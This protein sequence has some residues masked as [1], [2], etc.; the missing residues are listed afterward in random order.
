MTTSENDFAPTVTMHAPI[1][2]F[3]TVFIDA[4]GIG[5]I[6]PVLPDLIEQLTNLTTSEAAIWG[7]YLSVVYASMQFIFSPTIGNLSD[8][9]GRRP[10]LLLSLAMLGINYLL[11]GLAGSIIILFIGRFLSGVAAATMATANAYMA[12]IS[13]PEKRIQ[14]FG[15]LGAAFGMGFIVGP[16][17][18]GLIGELGVR[19]PFYAAAILSLLNCLYGFFVIPETLNEDRRRPFEWKRA[20]PLGSFKQMAQMPKVFWFLITMFFFSL[21][22]FVYPAVWNFFAKEA[23]DWGSSEIGLSLAAVGVCFAIVQGLL[24][25]RILPK[26]GA[27]KTALIGFIASITSLSFMAFITD[28]WMAYALLPLT[29]FGALIAPAMNG[30]MSNMISEN[31]QGELQG[32]VASINGISLVISP[33]IMTQ[34]FSY[35]GNSEANIYFPGAPF[36]LAA[37]LMTIALIPFYLGYSTSKVIYRTK[38]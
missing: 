4:M 17:I 16:A 8:R 29:G 26:F 21:G 38:V 22:H 28:G 23:F 6:M 25:R 18:G 3:M 7:G 15:L 34:L 2:I 10:I 5:L 32:A 31:T 14:N 36:L 19:A 12:D 33:F 1:F 35:F 11:M 37:L 24:I 20:N 27:V 9:F 13:P 30:I